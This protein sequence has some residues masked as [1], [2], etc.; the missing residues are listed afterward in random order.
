M[1]AG[2]ATLNNNTTVS[3][4]QALGGDPGVTSGT[5]FGNVVG[6][7]GCAASGGGLY[8]AGGVV[9]VSNAT[10]STNQAVGGY[11]G[12]AADGGFFLGSAAP[13][14]AAACTWRRATSR[15]LPIPSAAMSLWAAAVSSAGLSGTKLGVYSSAGGAASGGGLYAAGAPCHSTA[16][17]STAMLPRAEPVAPAMGPKILAQALT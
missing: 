2:T 5:V 11:A 8:V 12:H 16:M 4:N 10:L 7:N 15:S 17:P 14:T 1:A 3:G 6:G 13:R 9:T